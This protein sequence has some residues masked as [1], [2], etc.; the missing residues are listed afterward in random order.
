MCPS[1]IYSINES[2]DFWRY[3]IGVNVLPADT[4]NK[5]PLVPWYEWQDKP[6]PEQLHNQWKE[7]DVFSQGIAMIQERFGTMNTENIYTLSL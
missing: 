2:T 5:K 7:Q 4:K 6:I 3:Y 1:Q